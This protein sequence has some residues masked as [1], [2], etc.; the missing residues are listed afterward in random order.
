MKSVRV[1]AFAIL[2]HAVQMQAYFYLGILF[3]RTACCAFGFPPCASLY[4]SYISSTAR[5]LLFQK[6]SAPMPQAS[7][8]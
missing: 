1:C 3:S 8:R 5:G 6:V 7:A 2:L 4:T